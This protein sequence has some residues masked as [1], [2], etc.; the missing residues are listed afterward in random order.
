MNQYPEQWIRIKSEFIN[1]IWKVRQRTEHFAS[2]KQTKIV[3]VVTGGIC[4]SVSIM[5]VRVRSRLHQHQM[6]I[7]YTDDNELRGTS[8]SNND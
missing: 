3:V 7:H 8:L 2:L 6:F 4:S 5:H 1:N